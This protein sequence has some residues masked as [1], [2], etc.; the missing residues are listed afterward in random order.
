MNNF[1][2]ITKREILFRRRTK[3]RN[4]E[5]LILPFCKS[6]NLAKNE[7]I[8]EF[9]SDLRASTG[10]TLIRDALTDDPLDLSQIWELPL[11]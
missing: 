9:N 3:K 10:F 8:K 1:L 5:S 7:I 6:S 2:Q 4:L 11:N